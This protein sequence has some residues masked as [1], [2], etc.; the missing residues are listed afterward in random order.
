MLFERVAACL[1]N[2]QCPKMIVND[3]DVLVSLISN[4]ER[5]NISVYEI[6]LECYYFWKADCLFEYCSWQATSYCIFVMGSD[7]L[8]YKQSTNVL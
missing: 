5:S 4:F 6:V 3:S 2:V 7:N 1:G 8:C